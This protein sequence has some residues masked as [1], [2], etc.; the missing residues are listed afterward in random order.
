MR[1]SYFLSVRRGLREKPGNPNCEIW[2]PALY[3][4][5]S[6]SGGCH[7]QPKGTT[8]KPSGIKVASSSHRLI[9]E[10]SS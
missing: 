5:S 2:K 8:W 3:P 1:K 6:A 7:L 10:D 9:F 4:F